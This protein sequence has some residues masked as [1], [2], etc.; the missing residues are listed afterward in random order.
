VRD[1]RLDPLGQQPLAHARD[2]VGLVAGELLGLV[3]TPAALAS[4]ADQRRDGLPGD[5]LGPRRFVHLPRR[6]FDG[7]GS[8]RTASNHVEL[9]PKPASAAAQRVVGGLVRG[10]ATRLS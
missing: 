1:H 8:A 6:D 9:A 5:R 4:P 7:E 2:A 10:V 3:P